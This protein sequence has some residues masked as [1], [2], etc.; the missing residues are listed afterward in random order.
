[1]KSIIPLI[2]ALM[3]ILYFQNCSKMFDIQGRSKPE[4]TDPAFTP[5]IQEFEHYY[6]RSVNHIP[7]GFSDLDKRVAGVCYRSTMSSVTFSAHILIDRQYWDTITSYQKVNLIFHELGH[8][9]LNRPHLPSNAVIA[10]PSSFMFEQILT[11]ACIRSH[12]DSYI[13]EMFP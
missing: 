5:Y 6:G 13:E 9:A 2:F 4:A 1:M 7:I 10:C 8:C 3:T 12:Y 11:T